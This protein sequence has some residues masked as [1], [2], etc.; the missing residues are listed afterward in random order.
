MGRGK[1]SKATRKA[2]R[3]AENGKASALRA[4]NG[5][6][7]TRKELLEHRAAQQAYMETNR[8]HLTK[9]VAM[10]GLHKGLAH[11]LLTQTSIQ[12]VMSD[13]Q[14]RDKTARRVTI[15]ELYDYRMKRLK[16]SQGPVEVQE[17]K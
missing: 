9:E 3:N 7:M 12:Q 1:L 6:R 15:K 4:E 11:T 13:Y 14:R 10:N 17:C 5:K 2:S 8:A 16:D